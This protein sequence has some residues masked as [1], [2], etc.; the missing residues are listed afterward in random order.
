MNETTWKFIMFYSSDYKT[1][2]A[3]FKGKLL[4]RLCTQHTKYCF[5]GYNIDTG[6]EGK[7][8]G[9]FLIITKY[10][11]SSVS[12]VIHLLFVK[13]QA[14]RNGN[15]FSNLFFLRNFHG[16]ISKLQSPE[17]EFFKHAK[18]LQKQMVP[19]DFLNMEESYIRTKDS[20]LR[21]H[22]SHLQLLIFQFDHFGVC[23]AHLE[24]P[25][26]KLFKF[27]F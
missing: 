7:S 11:C 1:R 6:S 2:S 8:E 25:K 22:L 21:K 16:G 5:L 20:K 23:D 15:S 24:L 4:H 12:R 19:E 3:Y 10:V 27:S 18:A 26:Y 9:K 17:V 13:K 14:R